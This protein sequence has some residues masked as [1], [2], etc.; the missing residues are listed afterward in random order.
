MSD[1]DRA[2][3]NQVCDWIESER[4]KELEEE[5]LMFNSV[6]L[7][8]WREQ[9]ISNNIEMIFYQ[10][11]SRVP[12]YT[13][14]FVY[15]R[16]QKKVKNECV[17]YYDQSVHLKW[18]L[19]CILSIQFKNKYAILRF[20]RQYNSSPNWTFVVMRDR[21]EKLIEHIDSKIQ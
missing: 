9:P 6:A 21:A 18:G 19:Y 5:L 12:W 11:Y 16:D 8:D 13:P 3:L 17:E 14:A 10:K 2:A 7:Y 20:A 1:D 15:K 4:I